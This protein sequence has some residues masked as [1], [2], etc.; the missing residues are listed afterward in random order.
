MLPGSPSPAGSK[1]GDNTLQG[2]YLL[3]CGLSGP[4]GF[5]SPS[6]RL[7]LEYV[8][9]FMLIHNVSYV[10]PPFCCRLYAYIEECTIGAPM[11]E[12]Q[13]KPSNVFMGKQINR[14]VNIKKE[15][16]N[17]RRVGYSMLFSDSI[18]SIFLSLK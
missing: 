4:R 15:K 2:V 5:K 11:L 7:S 14:H 9:Y 17:M 13:R 18:M 6:R 8:F 1:P 16:P 3:A 10:S 12:E